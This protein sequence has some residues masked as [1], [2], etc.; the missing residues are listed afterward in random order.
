MLDIFKIGDYSKVER[1]VKMNTI[2]KITYDTEIK[3]QELKEILEIVE[4]Y[5]TKEV[6]QMALEGRLDGF[7]SFL[8]AV[9]DE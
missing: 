3:I 7:K 6:I 5:P 4:Q 2:E 1:E 8:K 9:K